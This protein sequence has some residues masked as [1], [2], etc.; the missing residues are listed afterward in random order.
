MTSQKARTLNDAITRVKGLLSQSESNW[1]EAFII[2]RKVENESTWMMAKGGCQSFQ[3]FLKVNF[4]DSIPYT[5]YRRGIAA[6]ELYGADFIK[7]VG[8]RSAHALMQDEIATNNGRRE[9]LTRKLEAYVRKHG[10]APR[11]S[12]IHI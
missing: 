11:L 8:V 4:P 12:L 6:I 2:L 9:T 7:K 5:F 3:E 1:V 10:T